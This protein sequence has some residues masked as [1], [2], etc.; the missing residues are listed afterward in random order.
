MITEQK[1]FDLGFLEQMDDK[2]FIVE[3]IVLYLHDTHH[4]LDEMKRLLDAGNV[5]TVYKTA[6]KLKSSTGI[7]QANTLFAILE[8]MEI[9]AKAG[10]DTVQLAQL[11]QTAQAEFDQL[12]IALELHLKEIDN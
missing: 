10:V 8:N 6:H 1:L 5:D 4:D 3:I 11:V 2:D 9:M 7:L 12:K